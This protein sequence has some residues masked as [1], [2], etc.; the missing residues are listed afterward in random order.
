MNPARPLPEGW[1]PSLGCKRRL[2]E[3]YGREIDLGLTLRKFIAYHSEGQVS[4]EWD[5]RF[6]TWVIT[7]VMRHRERTGGGTD[8]LGQPLVQRGSTPTPLA[9]GD[10]GY[11]SLDDLAETARQQGLAAQDKEQPC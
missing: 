9:P 11:V 5:A 1:Q 4:R 6:T 8:D 2:Y 3:E 7:D 10:V